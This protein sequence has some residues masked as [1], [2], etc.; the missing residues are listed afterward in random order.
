MKIL[1]LENKINLVDR[2][3]KSFVLHGYNADMIGSISL[4]KAVLGS[5]S[6]DLSLV[7]IDL[8][9]PVTN[10]QK[11]DF[12]L[13]IRKNGNL[14]PILFFSNEKDISGRIE[15]LESGATDYLVRPFSIAELIQKVEKMLNI[16]PTIA[17]RGTRIK[18]NSS[19]RVLDV[20]GKKIK[21]TKREAAILNYLINNSGEI[22]SREV[23]YENIW[24]LDSNLNSNVVD[25]HIK[26]I[27]KKIQKESKDDVIHTMWGL[28]YR[29]FDK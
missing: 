6:K 20:S 22:L 12:C 7:I 19:D 18:F 9:K 15:L 28:G 11:S 3:R 27:R 13:Y 21:L 24:T 8:D 1:V 26:N 4:A 25:V 23:I 14:M 2:L 10:K 29:F 17:E 5:S 16:K